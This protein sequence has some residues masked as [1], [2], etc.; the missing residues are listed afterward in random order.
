MSENVPANTDLLYRLHDRPNP[1]KAFLGAIQHVLAAFVGIITPSLIIG[2]TLGLGEHIPYLLSM[3]LIVSGV[4]TFIQTRKVGPIGSGLMALQG[5]SFGFLAAVLTA[6]F[7][8]KN[9]GGSPEEILSVIFGVSFLGAFVE[10]FLSQF[11]TKLKSFMSPIVTGCVIVTIGLSL[12]KVGLTDL[13]GGFGA[14]DFGSIPNLLL[15]GGVLVSVVLISII[16]NKVIRSSA[17]FIG[18]MLG[19]LAAVFMGRIDFSLVSKADFFTVPIPFKYGFGFDWQ[20]FIP[21]AFMYIITSIETSG[22]LTATS[23]ISGEPIK[24]PL[25]E[26]RIKG[27]VLGDGVNSLIAAVFNTFPVTT[28][29]QNNGVIQMTGIASRYVGFYVGGILCLMGLFPILGAI[30]TQLPKPVVGGVTLL[31]FATVATA[32]IR[33]LSTVDFTHRNVLII[34]TSLGLATGIAFVPDVLSQTPQFFQNIFGSAVTMS[35][36]VAITL[37]II[38]PKNYGVEFDT[39]EQHAEDGLKTAQKVA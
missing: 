36:I 37:D 33:I 28:F 32:G 35:G 23:M 6:G 30:F 34:A 38:L 13:A 11:I 1:I 4:A 12:T 16:N 2:G 20:A 7:V 25:Y 17:I 22:D 21:I 18:L 29:S 10:I 27:G 15:G 24:G 14:E 9:R 26:K 19:L 5:T 39:A 8:V 31:M 3:S